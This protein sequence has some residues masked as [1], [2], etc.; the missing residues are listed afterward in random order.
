MNIE[1]PI[2]RRY[3]YDVVKKLD[4]AAFIEREAQVK[5]AQ[6]GARWTCRCPMPHHRDK[7]PS[8]GVIRQPDGVYLFNCL[9]G[10]TKVITWDGIR[11]IGDMAGASQKILTKWGAWVVAP[12]RS[13]GKQE[14]MQIVLSRNGQKKI[15]RATPGHRWFIRS[16][17]YTIERTTVALQPNN[18][19]AWIFPRNF[20]RNNTSLSPQG[21]QHGIVFG[22]GS[23]LN[24]MSVVDL[25]GDKN[26]ELLKWFPLNRYYSYKGIKGM[27]YKKVLTMPLYYKEK[28][29]IDESHAYLA[30]WIAGWLAADGH[31]AK[32]GTVMLNSSLKP[33]LQFARHVCDRLG[34]GTYGITSQERVGIDEKKSLLHRLHFITEDLD[35]RFF[36]LKEHRSRFLNSEKK[37]SRRGWVVNSVERLGIFE[38]VFC[39][40]VPNSH[41]FVLEDHILTGN[42]FG[43]GSGGTI[44]DFCMDFWALDTLSQALSLIAR[45]MDLGSKEDMIGNAVR[46]IRVAVD[47][48]KRLETQ[49]IQAADCCNTVLRKYPD[50]ED[51]RQW[52]AIKYRQMNEML[53][54]ND[55][56]GLYQVFSDAVR[57]LNK[58]EVINAS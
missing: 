45:K 41:S 20:L 30:G 36:L 26:I 2:E 43:C 32:D 5:F 53:E 3:I 19:M 33:N 49:H 13:F 4:L 22:D 44:V 21:I 9:A 23:V 15:I 37:F 18:R 25:W 51:I 24:G 34:I 28:P 54:K 48:E 35:E 14:L 56:S 50:R 52:I 55:V 40:E 31:V 57:I 12:F 38:E 27:P 17:G 11:S 46:N 47:E 6:R 29:S 8:F 16:G 58:G 10:E 42:C 39:A 1:S 7:T